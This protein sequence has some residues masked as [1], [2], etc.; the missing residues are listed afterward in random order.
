[1]GNII[2]LLSYLFF[3]FL[4]GYY[5]ITTA[6]WYSYKLNR[7]IFHHTKAWW[8]IVYFLVPFAAYEALNFAHLNSLQPIVVVL[9]AIALFFWYRGL[10]KPLV[11]T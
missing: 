6:Q 5:F 2:N 8:N 3:L 11:W 4:L 1:M 9:Y 7:V 10:D